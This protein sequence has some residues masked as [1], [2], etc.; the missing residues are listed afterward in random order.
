MDYLL[1][2]YTQSVTGVY[3]Y[4]I[5]CVHVPHYRRASR[6]YTNPFRSDASDDIDSATT[7]FYE[8]LISKC[9]LKIIADMRVRLQERSYQST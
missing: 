5:R 7:Q 9:L 1:L 6:C 3:T 8:I 4:L 2:N